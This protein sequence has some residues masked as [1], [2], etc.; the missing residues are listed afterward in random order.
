MN[1]LQRMENL[2]AYIDGELTAEEVRLL[3]AWCE[4]H[5]ED[6][7]E[8]EA[9]AEVVRQVRE[10]P[11][12]DP[13]ADLEARILR[14]VAADEPVE[15]TREQA[16]EWLDEYL[17]GELSEPRRAVVE[18]Y[19]QTDP[20]FADLAE[21]HVAMLTSLRALDE[22]EPPADLQSRIEAQVAAEAARGTSTA[23]P[24]RAARPRQAVSANWKVALAAAAVLLVAALGIGRA[25]RD[26]GSDEPLMAQGDES[27]APLATPDTPADAAPRLVETPTEVPPVAPAIDA[28]QVP[29]DDSQEP[30]VVVAE[31]VDEQPVVRDDAP[32]P[33]RSTP[34]SGTV[35]ERK[36]NTRSDAPRLGTPSTRQPRTVTPQPPAA[37][38]SKSTPAPKAAAPAVDTS[39]VGLAE[40]DPSRAS[41]PEGA[42]FV[43][44]SGNDS[45]L[46]GDILGTEGNLRQGH[47]SPSRG[48]VD[49]TRRSEA[50]PF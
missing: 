41:R 16:L 34:S 47:E 39:G 29:F 32:A 25:F 1:R 24:K 46:G 4:S 17:D 28:P 21:L 14:A 42:E 36:R 45:V 3:F 30:V 15:A 11:E 49:P 18:H 50:P 7:A 5:P 13:P 22:A 35:A 12:V 23:R 40:K 10:L 27:G 38:R 2:S 37:P 20:E 6:A 31:P 33:R 26:G 8:Y 19:L 48:Q 43:T 44:G 9:L